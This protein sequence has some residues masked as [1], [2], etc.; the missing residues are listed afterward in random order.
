MALISVA[1]VIILP[2]FSSLSMQSLK[3]DAS[4]MSSLVRYLHEAAESKRLFYRLTFDLDNGSLNVERSSDSKK[5]IP[6]TESRLRTLTLSNGV[7][8]LDLTAP[9][10]G[11][12]EAGLVNVLLTPTGA[13]TPF[14]LHLSAGQATLTISFNPYSGKVKI[15]QG[16]L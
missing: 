5:Y 7:E 1:L 10:L 8:M 14:T 3:S 13:S 4:K 9:G 11:K 12:V 6:E 15:E 16:Y 2:R